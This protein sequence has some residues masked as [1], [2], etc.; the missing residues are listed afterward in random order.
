MRWKLDRFVR[1]GGLALVALIVGSMPVSFGSVAGVQDVCA[2]TGTCKSSPPD[3]C[4]V[5]GISY[6]DREWAGDRAD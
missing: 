2:Q 4:F 3:I 6:A 1:I 5:N